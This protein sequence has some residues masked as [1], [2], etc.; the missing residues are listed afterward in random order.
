MI[1]Y[2]AHCHYCDG[3]YA[4]EAYLKEAIRQGFVAYGFSSHAPLP[5]ENE[6]SMRLDQVQN[7]LDEIGELQQK[8]GAS[9]QIYKGMEVDF[10]PH[11]ISPQ[12]D[13]IQNLNLD[14][15]I[16][17]I[18]FVNSFSDGRLW[19]I[20]GSYKTFQKGLHTIFD[21]DITAVIH[22]YF[23]LTRQMLLEAQPDILGHL[24]KI[25]IQ[26]PNRKFYEPSNVFYRKEVE[27]TLEV[28]KET[29][30]IVEVNTRGVYKKWSIEPYPSYWILE[31]LYQMDIPIMLNSDAHHPREIAEGFSETMKMLYEIGF[32]ELQVLWD[33][34]WEAFPFTPHEILLPVYA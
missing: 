6:W 32:R 19:E 14:Y 3:K 30:V 28:I 18:H 13:F 2:H 16:G 15:T 11:V 29:G 33:N 7:Y 22:R 1:N 4:P 34:E 8:Y 27:K 9:L 5:F 12:A 21:N 23:E 17:S 20:D 26:H 10:I 31:R 25:K 24:D